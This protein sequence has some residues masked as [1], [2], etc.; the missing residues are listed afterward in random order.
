MVKIPDQKQQDRRQVSP[1]EQLVA[2]IKEFARLMIEKQPGLRGMEAVNLI[3]Q[4]AL[5]IIPDDQNYLAEIIASA[6][7][8]LSTPISFAP[9]LDRDPPQGQ[10]HEPCRWALGALLATEGSSWHHRLTH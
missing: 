9:Y 5:R 3:R 2:E 8:I 1:Y 7:H 6:P 4:E 10:P